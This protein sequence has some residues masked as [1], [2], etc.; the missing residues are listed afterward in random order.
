MKSITVELHKAQDAEECYAMRFPQ[1]ERWRAVNGYGS[2]FQRVWSVE[3]QGQMEAAE[4][5]LDWDALLERAIEA[6]ELE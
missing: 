4:S 5:A 1:E 3:F 2:Q 6:Y